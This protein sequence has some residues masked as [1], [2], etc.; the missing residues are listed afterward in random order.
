M[1]LENVPL[2]QMRKFANV[3]W[4]NLGRTGSKGELSIKEDLYWEPDLDE[5]RRKCIKIR[6][7]DN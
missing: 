5:V 4:F 3:C 2:T 6:A 7:M 1:N